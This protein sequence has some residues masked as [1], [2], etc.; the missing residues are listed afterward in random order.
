MCDF[1]FFNILVF[2]YELLHWNFLHFVIKYELLNTKKIDRDIAPSEDRQSFTRTQNGITCIIFELKHNEKK[3]RSKKKKTWENRKY[4]DRKLRYSH[5]SVFI[6]V[7]PIY[8]SLI[9]PIL[10]IIFRSLY[11]ILIPDVSFPISFFLSCVS[12]LALPFRSLR[13]NR[14]HENN[15]GK[16][17]FVC[18]GGGLYS[19]DWRTK[20]EN[21]ANL[22]ALI[23]HGINRTK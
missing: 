5:S 18:V 2:W 8:R 13:M 20:T 23:R 9:M 3:R 17:M 14:N 22:Y 12:L 10:F 15:N 16:S 4:F 21:F 19:Q 6:D 7:I 1:N 11:L